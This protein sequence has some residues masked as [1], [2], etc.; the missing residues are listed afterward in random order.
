MK[1]EVIE[2]KS[3]RE[4]IRFIRFPYKLY[5][6]NINY[7][8]ELNMSIKNKIS[9]KNPFLHHSEIALFIAVKDD[10]DVGRIAVIHNITHLEVYNDSSGFFGYFD[11]FDDIEV[12]KALFDVASDWLSKKGIKSMIGPTNLTTNDS[13]G[14]LIK[15]FEYPNM[16]SMPYN[17]EYYDQLMTHCGFQ[18]EVDL[19]AYKIDGRLIKKK[20]GNILERSLQAMKN[21]GIVIRP[22]SSKTFKHDL[23]RLKKAYNEC[24]INNWGFMPLNEKEFYEMAKELKMIAPLDLALILEKDEEIIGFVMAAPDINQAI[25]YVYKGK[26]TLVGILKLLWYKRKIN[27]GRVMILGV[28]EAHKGRGLDLVL[29]HKITQALYNLKIYEADASY[30]LEK[31]NSMN[32]VLKKIGGNCIKEYRIYKKRIA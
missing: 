20:Y 8:G 16:I 4:R 23:N 31:N 14:I 32:S 10:Q 12:A 2:V 17:F 26:L 30:V 9:K 21:N 6:S 19:Y 25:K 29:C 18:K 27:K 5:K 1:I 22:I 28:L 11:S 13:C 7:V 24:N 15:G 3:S